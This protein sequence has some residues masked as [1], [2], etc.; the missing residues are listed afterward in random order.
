M[1]AGSAGGALTLGGDVAVSDSERSDVLLEPAKQ[2]ML[3]S[4]EPR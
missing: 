2:A 3:S 1:D 4:G